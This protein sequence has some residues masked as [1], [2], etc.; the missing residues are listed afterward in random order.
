MKVKYLIPSTIWAVIIA[1][2]CGLPPSQLPKVEEWLIPI[3]KIAHATFFF[4]FAYLLSIA[5]KRQQESNFLRNHGMK[6]SLLVGII[7]GTIIELL[8]LYIFIKRDAEF[9]DIGAD[10]FGSIAGTFIF[11]MIFSKVIQLG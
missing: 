8:Q 10:V 2:L 11:Y 3:D 6:I 1:I 9:A 5:L 7:Y 4:V